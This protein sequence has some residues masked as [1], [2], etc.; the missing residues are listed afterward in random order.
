MR[1]AVR[2][3][4]ETAV[5]KAHELQQGMVNMQH[6]TSTAQNQWKM[7]LQQAE[8]N[9]VED[10]ASAEADHHSIG[11]ILND[12]LVLFIMN[13]KDPMFVT[14]LQNLLI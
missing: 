9:Y 2:S 7:Y 1:T 11:Q 4:S 13:R 12:W 14:V 5:N 3:M 8:D 6:L 10:T